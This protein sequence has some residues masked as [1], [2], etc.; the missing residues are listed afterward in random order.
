MNYSVV[1]VGDE[2]TNY[3][4]S[5]GFNVVHDKT[6]HDYPA[7]TGSYTRSKATVE[8]AL[9]SNPSDIIIDLHRDAIGSK[10]DYDPS[11]KI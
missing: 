7:Y 1:R 10:S 4:M 2:L 9:K 3:L 8:N 11:V 5:F 6:Y